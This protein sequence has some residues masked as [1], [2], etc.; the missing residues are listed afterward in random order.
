MKQI[1]I[2]GASRSLDLHI[3]TCIPVSLTAVP[4]LEIPMHNDHLS[5]KKSIY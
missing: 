2:H 1:L 3:Y 5:E 4:K